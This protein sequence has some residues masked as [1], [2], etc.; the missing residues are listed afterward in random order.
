M[1]LNLYKKKIKTSVASHLIQSETQ[2]S[3]IIFKV[4]EDPV[5]A[6]VFYPVW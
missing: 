3:S 2:N 1:F 6:P 4:L 5:P